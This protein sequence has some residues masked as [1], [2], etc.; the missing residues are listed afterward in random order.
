MNTEAAV[1]LIFFAGTFLLLAVLENRAPRRARTH[2]R[3][4]R[5]FSNL[6]LVALNPLCVRLVF[7]VLPLGLALMATER[8]WGVLS[9]VDFPYWLEVA[10]GVL[11][12]DLI[13]YFQHVLHHAIPLLWRFHMVHHADLDFDLTTGV[14]FHPN[15]IV[16]SMAI[17][18][19]AI[20]V[21]GPPVLSVL[22]FEVCLNALSMFN[23]SNV[24]IPKTLDRFIRSLIVTPDMHRVHHSAI[25]C[26]T[27][28][29][30]GFCFSWWDRLLGTYKDQPEQ[31][32]LGMTIGL[33][34]FRDSANLNLA[35]LL[36]LPFKGDI[37]AVPINRK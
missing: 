10:I 13:I 34:Q 11:A 21:V 17:K 22:A 37:G 31:G 18:L 2:A 23:H 33:S 25:I 12:L 8:G 36:I 3:S 16:I 27:N 19:A 5:W 35:S 29:N 20:V 32:H 4:N 1:R 15:A 7:P 14:R 26:E 24:D 30:Y 28:S 6:G 9:H